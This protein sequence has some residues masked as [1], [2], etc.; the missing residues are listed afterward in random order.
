MLPQ[1]KWVNPGY[2]SVKDDERLMTATVIFS[3]FSSSCFTFIVP[4]QFFR[5]P[6]E[7]EEKT[8]VGRKYKNHIAVI[9]LQ[10]SAETQRCDWQT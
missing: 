3:S 4:F 9:V 8:D 10:K 5:A 6:V 2:F 7:H 1:G